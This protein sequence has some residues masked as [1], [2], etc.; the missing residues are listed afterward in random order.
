MA[1][2][3]HLGEEG[4]RRHRITCDD[5]LHTSVIG[6]RAL[7]LGPAHGQRLVQEVSTVDMDEIEEERP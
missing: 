7:Q 2:L 1:S 6:N 4:L 3:D 5:P